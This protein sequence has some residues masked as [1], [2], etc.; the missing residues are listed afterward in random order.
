MKNLILVCTAML[1]ATAAFAA[2]KC[3]SAALG[4]AEDDYG[5]APHK[6]MV[7]TVKAGSTYHVAVGIGNAEDGEHDYEI[8][9]PNGCESKPAVRELGDNEKF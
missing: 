6:A 7:K 2:D 8:T 1:F 3:R 5:N 9:F 4:A